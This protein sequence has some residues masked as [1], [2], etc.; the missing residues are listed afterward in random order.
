MPESKET[1]WNELLKSFEK[2]LD[3]AI[4]KLEEKDVDSI[5][6]FRSSLILIP[7]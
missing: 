5:P 2:G 7:I 3:K 6:S 4:E 1:T